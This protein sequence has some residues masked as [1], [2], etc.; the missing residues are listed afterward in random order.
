MMQTSPPFPVTMGVA[1][2]ERMKKLAAYLPEEYLEADAAKV[3]DDLLKFRAPMS[4]LW[5][6]SAGPLEN[7]AVSR[8]AGKMEVLP[9]PAVVQGENQLQRFGG[10]DLPFL[11]APP[12]S[13]RRQ[14]LSPRWKGWTRKC[15]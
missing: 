10:T 3:L 4:V 11:S 7:P 6:S 9:A 2:L 5:V 15:W 13:R 14:P 1:T 12:M 8:V